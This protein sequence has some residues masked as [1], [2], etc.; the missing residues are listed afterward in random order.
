MVF[1]FELNLIYF[2]FTRLEAKEPGRVVFGILL[3]SYFVASRNVVTRSNF[4]N[5]TLI[6]PSSLR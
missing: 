3:R 4:M 6:F 1:N 5:S 2:S